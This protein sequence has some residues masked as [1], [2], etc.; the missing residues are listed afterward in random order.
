M[1]MIGTGHRFEAL[2]VTCAWC[3][4][5]VAK[6]VETLDNALNHIVGLSLS[7]WA[8]LGAIFYSLMQ[9]TLLMPKFLRTIK[10]WLHGIF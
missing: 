2:K 9:I 4:V 7:D 3:G 5:G 1:D 6:Y 10:G 8:A